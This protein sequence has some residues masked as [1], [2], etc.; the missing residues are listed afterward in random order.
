MLQEEESS[1]NYNIVRVLICLS[2]NPPGAEAD[3]A[4]SSRLVVARLRQEIQ[5]LCQEDGGRAFQFHKDP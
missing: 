4:H 2:N 1:L 5:K 3:I